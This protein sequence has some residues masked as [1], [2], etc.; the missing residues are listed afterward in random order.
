MRAK[1]SD[2]VGA[3]AMNFLDCWDLQIVT[4]DGIWDVPWC[5]CYFS[6]GFRLKTFENFNIGGGGCAPW[7]DAICP[8]RCNGYFINILYFITYYYYYLIYFIL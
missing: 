1:S 6:E 8:D 4:D 3:E 7:L 5:R 2:V